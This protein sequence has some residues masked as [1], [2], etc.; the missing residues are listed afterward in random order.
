MNVTGPQLAEELSNLAF[1][2]GNVADTRANI[3]KALMVE[4]YVSERMFPALAA[5]AEERGRADLAR[6]YRNMA[7]GEA[8]HAQALREALRLLDA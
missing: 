4:D 3:L 7:Q 6:F 2:Q 5:I 8:Q 1:V